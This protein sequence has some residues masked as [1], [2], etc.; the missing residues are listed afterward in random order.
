MKKTAKVFIAVLVTAL[1]AAFAAVVSSAEVPDLKPGSDRV[2]FIKDLPEG[3]TGRGLGN[4]ADDPLIPI[5][6]P[7]GYDP[8]ATAPKNH[9]RTAFIQAIDAL[10]ETGGTVVICGPV[11]FG[12]EQSWGTGV[13]QKDV[14]TPVFK[15]NTIK[16]TSVYD[17][18]DYRET[19]D[20]KIMIASPAMINVKGQTIWENLDIVTVD[21]GR[22]ISFGGYSTIVGDGVN[23]YPEEEDFE[24]VGQ[25][26]LSLIAGTRYEKMVA[27]EGG[28]NITT[29]LLVKSGTYSTIVGANW[30]V[31][32]AAPV[33]GLDTNLYLEGTTTV[34]TGINGAVGG[35]NRS[36]FTGNV[37]IVINGGTYECDICGGSVS[38]FVNDD[39]VVKITINGGTFLDVWSLDEM[40]MGYRFNPPAK[41]TLDLS[42]YQGEYANLEAIDSAIGE[43]SEVIWPANW[44]GP[45][46][47]ATEPETEAET[48]P[49]TE[50]ADSAEVT[51]PIDDVTE[52]VEE[53]E[54]VKAPESDKKATQEEKSEG[55]FPWLI[56]GII[57]GVVVVC[58]AVAAVILSK[59]KK[60]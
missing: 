21:S 9:L 25:Y 13:Y 28:P 31:T 35:L 10:K 32:D 4:S 20:A 39:A 26:Y 11:Y 54:E 56:V 60:A 38:S 36:E 59:K 43:F 47:V 29:N 24:G 44:E 53:T 30:G 2:I 23:T 22:A 46:T 58:G 50:P 1:F 5:S 40:A 3:Y 14:M 57:A 16:F 41:S 45:K 51:E 55:G 6:D 42:G 8:T 17:G 37:N 52:P 19:A 7:E 48:E 27:P 49:E 34:L 33:T 15:E 18:V 12:L